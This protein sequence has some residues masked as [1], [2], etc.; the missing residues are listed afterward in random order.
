VAKGFGLAISPPF[1]EHLVDEVRAPGSRASAAATRVRSFFTL[2]AF[3]IVSIAASVCSRASS[4][5]SPLSIDR[6]AGLPLC[7]W[8][9]I[10]HLADRLV[11]VAAGD[12]A[13]EL[14]AVTWRHRRARPP[15][16][17]WPYR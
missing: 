17:P 10:P 16:L 14:R 2:S 9:S 12:Q 3:T 4:L 11:G 1:L 13:P 15:L 8:A 6:P 7:H 5:S